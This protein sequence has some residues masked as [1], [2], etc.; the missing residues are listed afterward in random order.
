MWRVSPKVRV[1]GVPEQCALPIVA[2]SLP[3]AD[4]CPR[5]IVARA[6]EMVPNTP[7]FDLTGHPSLSLPCG[8]VDGLPVGLMLTGRHFE[9][10]T[11]YQLAYAYEQAT[12]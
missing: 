4:A 12:A 3:A 5:E 9:E 6:L 1:V 8:E 10:A 7:A 11:L 2:P